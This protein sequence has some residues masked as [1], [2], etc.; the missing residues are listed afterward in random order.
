M[1]IMN[2]RSSSD[3][4]AIRVTL[5]KATIPSKQKNFRPVPLRLSVRML[6]RFAALVVLFIVV[7]TGFVAADSVL[8]RRTP[9]D[10]DT[11][12]RIIPPAAAED[13]VLESVSLPAQIKDHEN[14]IN[15]TLMTK[16][17]Y[18]QM[19]VQ[20]PVAITINNHTAARP[21]H[22][23]SKADIVGEFLAEGGITR[24]VPVYLQ[25]RDVEKIGPVR[26][27]RY[28]M[29]MFVSAFADPVILHEGQAGYDNA[30]WETYREEADARGAIYRWG[31][32]S[33][34]SA[35]SRYRDSAKAR[36]SGYVHSLYTD[37]SLINK[38]LQR[39][40]GS[41]DY[42]AQSIKPLKFK[43]DA[44]VTERGNFASVDIAFL[45]LARN[46]YAARFVYD[47]ASNTYKRFIAGR[48]DIDLLTG[49]QI[50][51][52]NVIIEWHNY[53]EANDGHNRIIID[54]LGEDRAV[55][56]RDGQVIEGTWKKDDRLE[57]ARYFDSDGNEIE[58]VRG[59]IWTVFA[60]K[61][62]DRLVTNVELNYNEQNETTAE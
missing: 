39:L 18:D 43:H 34:Q 60:V 50:A 53:G 23:L 52:K 27:L 45:S 37:F 54:M 20:H 28:Y 30:P 51:P 25:H 55:I 15:G 35:G 24:Y 49:E 19:I 36:S 42:G 22:G 29:I 11:E 6:A 16:D 40:S 31:L 4:R 7:F 41:W 61:V 8:Q 47:K 59:Q 26:S 44:P 58:L 46:D 3:K 14:P 48:E 33:L 13:I 17:A 21:Q 32:K 9:I 57:R 38:E 12:F 10:L 56:L 62:G 5:D 1:D 2:K